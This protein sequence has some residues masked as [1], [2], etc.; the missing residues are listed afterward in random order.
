MDNQILGGSTINSSYSPA[1]EPEINKRKPHTWYYIAIILFA[2]I[3]VGLLATIYIISVNEKKSKEKKYAAMGNNRQTSSSAI[4]GNSGSNPVPSST[5]APTAFQRKPIDY[6]TPVIFQDKTGNLSLE[7]QLK[8]SQSNQLGHFTLLLNH[9]EFY[10]GIIPVIDQSNDTF[11]LTG[12]A[13]AKYTPDINEASY[14]TSSKQISIDGTLNAA[15]GEAALTITIDTNRFSFTKEAPSVNDATQ[16]ATHIIELSNQKNWKDMY[17]LLMSD[18]QKTETLE[19]FIAIMSAPISEYPLNSGVITSYRLSGTG[20]L[21]FMAGNSYFIQP[22]ESTIKMND[23]STKVYTD[24]M[25]LIEEQG[26]WKFMSNDTPTSK[27]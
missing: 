13:S 6:S 23:G 3:L 5:P 21:Q 20:V 25:V 16:V 7:I 2:C 10:D 26:K 17:P 27:K 19:E 9:E 4:S 15:N 1:I 18:I 11:R 14:P 12:T 8:N 24:N 22:E